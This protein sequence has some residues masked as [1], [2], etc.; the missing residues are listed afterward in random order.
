MLRLT[1][2]YAIDLDSLILIFV[3]NL[4]VLSGKLPLTRCAPRCAP[5][6]APRC[7]HALPMLERRFNGWTSMFGWLPNLDW[8]CRWFGT[9]QTGTHWCAALVGCSQSMSD[10]FVGELLLIFCHSEDSPSWKFSTREFLVEIPYLKGY[11]ADF[12][13]LIS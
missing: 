1:A 12:L 2:N 13:E 4:L 9:C 10:W 7:L 5:Q 11:D 8:H 3:Q 6:Y